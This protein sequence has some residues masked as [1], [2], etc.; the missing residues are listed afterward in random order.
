M[1]R[2][3]AGRTI[4]HTRTGREGRC[5]GTPRQF[6][7]PLGGKHRGL[8]V[9]GVDDPK[10]PLGRGVKQREDVAARESEQLTDLEGCH[11]SYRELPAAA[12]DLLGGCLLERGDGPADTSAG[13]MGVDLRAWAP[14]RCLPGTVDRMEFRIRHATEADLGRYRSTMIMEFRL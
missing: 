3:D 4:G 9:A 2:G 8:F 5:S 13:V 6:R 7:H 10:T 11:R 14:R 1:G 12:R